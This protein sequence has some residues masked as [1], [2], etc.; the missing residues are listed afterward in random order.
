MAD[1]QASRVYAWEAEAVEP[2]QRPQDTLLTMTECRELVRKA[3]SR[4]LIEPPHVVFSTAQLANCWADP[5]NNRIRICKWGH[6]GVTVLHEVAHL[7]TIDAIIAGENPHGPSFVGRAIDFY[8]FYLGMDLR[9]LLE[10]AAR[11]GLSA[12]APRRRTPRTT[13]GSPFSEIDF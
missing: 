11:F 9:T 12:R 4:S 2:M 13:S 7:A 1:E 3:S 10:S 6:S 8:A 5:R